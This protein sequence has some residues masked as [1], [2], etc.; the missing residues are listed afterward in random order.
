MS[1]QSSL[2]LISP[3][4]PTS[5]GMDWVTITILTTDWNCNGSIS[6]SK[7]I[8][9]V[10]LCKFSHLML[11]FLP[12]LFRISNFPPRVTWKKNKFWFLKFCLSA[13][14]TNK[15]AKKLISHNFCSKSYELKCILDW[16]TD[17]SK[18]NPKWTGGLVTSTFFELD[19]GLVLVAF[20]MDWWIRCLWPYL[21]FALPALPGAKIAQPAT[22]SVRGTSK[23]SH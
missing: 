5:P 19:W 1:N 17:Q 9:P 13:L 21:T 2:G 3:I 6:F 4:S 8:Q 12:N 20:K 7:P 14:Y 23:G 15:L 16:W 18:K 11:Q 22:T 10:H